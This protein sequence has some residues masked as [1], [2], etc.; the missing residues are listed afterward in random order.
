M[1]LDNTDGIVIAF[2]RDVL[3]IEICCPDHSQL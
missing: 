1:G 2:S 3:S